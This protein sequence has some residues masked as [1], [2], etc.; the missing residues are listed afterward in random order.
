MT[1]TLED[2]TEVHAVVGMWGQS[3]MNSW[4]TRRG[5]GDVEGNT[6]QED[7]PWNPSFNSYRTVNGKTRRLAG[8]SLIHNGRKP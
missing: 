2:G 7:I 4:G 3:S 1:F 5:G 8:K 6:W